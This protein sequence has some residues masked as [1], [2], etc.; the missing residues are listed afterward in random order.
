MIIAYPAIYLEIINRRD[1]GS[2][3]YRHV[4]TTSV[5]DSTSRGIQRR[6]AEAGLFALFAKTRPFPYPESIGYLRPNR[7]SAAS[8]A[9]PVG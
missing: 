5:C 2:K 9:V 4:D 7:N 8:G 6:L 3:Y 1:R